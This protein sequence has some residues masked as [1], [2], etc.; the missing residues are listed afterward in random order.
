MQ[1]SKREL[2]KMG[3][4]SVQHVHVLWRSIEELR[5]YEAGLGI[6]DLDEGQ[7]WSMPGCGHWEGV[8]IHARTHTVTAT[9]LMYVYANY[10]DAVICLT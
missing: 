1:V 6:P 2:L 9:V 5:E 4:S 10:G 8:L 7:C 3:A